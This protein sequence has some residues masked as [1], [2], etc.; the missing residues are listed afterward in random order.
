MIL[1]PR[2]RTVQTV[3]AAAAPEEQIIAGR[4]SETLF[5]P[6]TVDVPTM[7]NRQQHIFSELLLAEVQQQL[8]RV[9]VKDY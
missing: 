2:A 4:R 1:F 8:T 3:A 5:N 6:N 9:S 7:P